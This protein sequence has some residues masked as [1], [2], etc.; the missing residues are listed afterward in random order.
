MDLNGQSSRRRHFGSS[1]PLFVAFHEPGLSEQAKGEGEHQVERWLS[2]DLD[3]TRP[4]TP[5]AEALVDDIEAELCTDLGKVRPIS[6]GFDMRKSPPS[7]GLLKNMAACGRAKILVEPEDI[8]AFAAMPDRPNEVTIYY[9][10]DR[11]ATISEDCERASGEGASADS[12]KA[13]VMVVAANESFRVG[14]TQM[15]R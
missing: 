6:M 14:V 8:A 5:P 1:S 2:S 12:V 9:L 4:D 13:C 7:H 3:R 10:A 11:S 15:P